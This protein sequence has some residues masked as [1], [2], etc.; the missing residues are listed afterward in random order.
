MAKFVNNQKVDFC[1]IHVFNL[2]IH[3]YNSSDFHLAFALDKMYLD[4]VQIFRRL[5]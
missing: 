1:L 5:F 2:K 4:K 3:I